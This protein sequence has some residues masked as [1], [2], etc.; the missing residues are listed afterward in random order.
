MSE[1][2]CCRFMANSLTLCSK[3]FLIEQA[4]LAIESVE[5][6]SLD[7]VSRLTSFK[8]C[9]VDESRN[10]NLANNFVL[11]KLSLLREQICC[12]ILIQQDGVNTKAEKSG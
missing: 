12:Q 3:T 4:A 5:V 10:F 1:L 6:S 11:G 2:N 7:R 9:E 8:I